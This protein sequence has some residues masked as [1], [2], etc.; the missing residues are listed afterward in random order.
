MNESSLIPTS[1]LSDSSS[2]DLSV[3][4]DAVGTAACASGWKRY[5]VN[6]MCYKESST[7]MSWYAAED[8]CWGQRA[9][10]HLVSV[11]S[12]AEAQWLNSQ[13]KVWYAP[14]DD[15]IGLKKECDMGKYFWTD[16]SPVDFTWWQPGYP[17]AQY[18][19]QSYLEYSIVASCFWIHTGAIR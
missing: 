5:S 11:H 16:G 12:Q 9:G 3:L 17:K 10:A 13:Y 2:A 8:W 15:W 1:S 18:A 7:S 6:G 14:M 19:E 4:S